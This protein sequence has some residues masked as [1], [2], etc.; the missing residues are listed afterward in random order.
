M[1][2]TPTFFP[3]SA[4]SFLMTVGDRI[5]RELTHRIARFVVAVDERSAAGIVDL[6]PSYTTILAIYDPGITSGRDLQEHFVRCWT[7]S[8]DADVRTENPTVVI[9]VI[10]GDEFGEDLPEVAAH[11]QLPLEEVIERHAGG[12]Y[13]VGAL[14]FSPGFAYLIGLDP[15]LATP[16]RSRPRTHVPSG[17]IGIG[18]EQTGI[19]ALES[20]GG[21][22]LIGRTPMVLF[23]P[24]SDSPFPLQMGGELR[25]ERLSPG[26]VD[27]AMF[28]GPQRDDEPFGG[29]IDVLSPGMQTTVQDLGRYGYG[30]FGF[31]PNGAADRASLIAA[32]RAV[33]NPDD[34]ACLEITFTGPE[35]IFF[36]RSEV[37]VQG[38]DFGT[39]LNGLPLPVGRVQGVMP[40]D[41]LCFQ[42][43]SGNGARAYL[44]VAGGIDVA[45]V[46]GSR[47]T[48]LTAGIGGYRGRAL[49]TGDRLPIGRLRRSTSAG[50]IEPTRLGPPHSFDVVPGPQANRFDDAAWAT[51]LSQPFTVS[52][53]SNR[54]GLRL[55]GPSIHPVDTADIISEGIVTGSIQI[56]G[57]GQPIVMLPGHATIGGYTKIAT[58]VED[59][60][61][62]LGQLRPGDELRF[63]SR[64][65]TS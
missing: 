28:R 62:R 12:S 40:G 58:V 19:Y 64:Y 15:G 37:V 56:T 1:M 17:S 26:D 55:D 32:N 41:E 52:P 46:M 11:H 25:F 21:W 22:N 34:A 49:H 60:L 29:E 33:G 43:G 38:A 39:T 45:P 6:I 51:L 31:A 50:S 14:G 48:D 63:T 18:G 20:P 44:A 27:P 7:S 61:D 10:Y 59:D 9:P 54:M 2:E 4:S 57:E 16:R 30:R 23:D 5:D 53:A 47:S 36:Q 24:G 8:N 35:L 13:T 3:V 65:R 42:G